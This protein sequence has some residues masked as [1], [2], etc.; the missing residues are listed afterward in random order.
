M[1][2]DWAVLRLGSTCDALRGSAG[3]QGLYFSELK[4][5]EGANLESN[6]F[7]WSSCRLARGRPKGSSVGDGASSAGAAFESK[8]EQCRVVCCPS[9]IM[10]STCAGRFLRSSTCF[11]VPRNCSA[12][13]NCTGAGNRCHLEL[14]RPVCCALPRNIGQGVVARGT[15]DSS[16]EKSG[17]VLIT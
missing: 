12:L 7:K 17:Q 11:V 15:W 5:L 2:V 1:V 10:V 13:A 6:S 3:I 8:A 14:T 9:V 4:T 16:A